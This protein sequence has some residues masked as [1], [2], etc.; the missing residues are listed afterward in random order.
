MPGNPKP[1][2]KLCI[3]FPYRISSLM[4]RDGGNKIA[5]TASERVVHAKP[6]GTLQRP[7]SYILEMKVAQ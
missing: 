6:V 2:A 3:S 4:V 1:R 7:T 5:R